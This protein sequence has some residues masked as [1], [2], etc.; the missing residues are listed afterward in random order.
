MKTLHLIQGNG[1]CGPLKIALFDI[2]EKPNHI[3]YYPLPLS[4]GALP[5]NTSLIELQ[6]VIRAFQQIKMTYSREPELKKFFSPDLSQ[7][8]RV[9]IWWSNKYRPDTHLILYLVCRLYPHCDLYHMQY[10]DDELYDF[11]IKYPDGIVPITNEERAKYAVQY[12]ELLKHD[13][14]LRLY[15]DRCHQQIVNVSEDYFDQKILSICKTDTPI[16]DVI[17]P[18]ICEYRLDGCRW[19]IESRILWL[20]DNGKLAI[21][22]LEWFKNQYSEKN[23]TR[24][25]QELT[26]KA[27]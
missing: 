9:V 8:D 19:Y 16:E 23:S 6:R 20:Y 11:D 13:S 10:D 4:F 21:S 25:R 2:G 7:F 18:F 15:A 14:H 17:H 22:D 5:H 26:I 24:D 3:L 1:N 27:L 12:D